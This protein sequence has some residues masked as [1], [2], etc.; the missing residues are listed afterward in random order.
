MDSAW[1]DPIQH[2]IKKDAPQIIPCSSLYGHKE[3]V[4]ERYNNN[5]NMESST[6]KY[7]IRISRSYVWVR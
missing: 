3:K 1:E 5:N 6:S 4:M 2:A 7:T